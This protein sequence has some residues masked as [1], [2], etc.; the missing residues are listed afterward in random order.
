MRRSF[1]LVEVLL[2]VGIVS[3]LSTVV[4]VSLR[5]A[6][7]FAQANNIKRQSDLTLIINAV[8]R[9]A[10][11]NRS[12]FPPGVTAIPQF[13]SSSGADICAD[14]VPKYLP[15]LPT[16][17]TAFSGAD[18][19]CT[20]PYDTGYLISLTSDGGHVTVSAPSAQEGEVITFTR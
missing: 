18:V 8:F 6:S 9:Y 2:V 16:D 7:R 3:L 12:V 17:P 4:M 14:L 10:S 5:P 11:D 1:T 19:P 20:P 13:I 15:S